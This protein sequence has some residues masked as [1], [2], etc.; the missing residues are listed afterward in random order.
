[1]MIWLYFYA[2][3][4]VVIII[5]S[6]ILQFY[7]PLRLFYGD[8]CSLELRLSGVAM[9]PVVS[10]SP[11]LEEGEDREKELKLGHTLAEDTV[12]RTLELKNDTALAVRFEIE[13]DSL[14]PKHRR[15]RRPNSFSELKDTTCHFWYISLGEGWIFAY[16][17]I[18]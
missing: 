8:S 4:H 9:E 16:Q 15:K 18:Q 1:M 11:R 5:I 7:E 17:S 2:N 13:M 10:L 12:T 6:L 3:I 14:L